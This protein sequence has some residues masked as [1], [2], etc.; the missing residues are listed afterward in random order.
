ML[1]EGASSPAEG[2]TSAP[3]RVRATL[4]QGTSA[5]DLDIVFEDITVFYDGVWYRGAG[6]TVGRVSLSKVRKWACG[7]FAGITLQRSPPNEKKMVKNSASEFIRKVSISATEEQCDA[8]H[9]S[10]RRD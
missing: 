5:V 1:T 8:W 6:G 7:L 10:L 3:K 4:L 2:G 9:E